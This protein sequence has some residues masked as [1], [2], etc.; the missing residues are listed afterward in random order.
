MRR[1][2][3][4]GLFFCHENRYEDDEHDLKIGVLRRSRQ[5]LPAFA[6][7]AYLPRLHQDHK[8]ERESF[9]SQRYP[10]LVGDDVER[11]DDSMTKVQFSQK[12]KPFSV[13]ERSTIATSR[14]RAEDEMESLMRAKTP[15]SGQGHESELII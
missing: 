9:F 1:L 13:A 11:Q 12:R 8:R 4:S 14:L 2:I 6:E 7:I 5:P 15:L 10:D 3:S